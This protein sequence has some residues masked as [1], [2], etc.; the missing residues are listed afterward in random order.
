MSS[1]LIKG[2]KGIRE[3]W[4]LGRWS[5]R[6]S[7]NKSSSRKVERERPFVGVVEKARG[8]ALG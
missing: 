5:H 8:K 2:W 3:K 6:M 4:V 7:F 1:N